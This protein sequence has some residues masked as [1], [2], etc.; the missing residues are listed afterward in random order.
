[1]VFG[2]P[3]MKNVRR[4]S[5]IVVAAKVEDISTMKGNLECASLQMS[6]LVISVTCDLLKFK[7]SAIQ[8]SMKLLDT[9]NDGECLFLNWDICQFMLVESNWLL[10]LI[11]VTM[12]YHSS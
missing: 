5:L 9:E 12:R 1:M 7:F 2:N 3:S 10:C 11:R 8:I 4:R 6:H